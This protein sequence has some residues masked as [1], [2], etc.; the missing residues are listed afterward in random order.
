M[1]T[2]N[3]LSVLATKGNLAVKSAGETVHTK[4]GVNA[5]EGELV[6]FNPKTN[7]TLGVSDLATASSIAIGVGVKERGKVV[8]RHVGGDSFNLKKD[9]VTVTATAPSC[10]C[11]Q[12]VDIFPTC[13]Q[14]DETY[15]INI[16][17]DDYLV[18]SRF[19]FNDQLNYVFTQEL[20]CD[21]CEDCTV[22]AD[23][24]KWLSGLRDKINGKYRTELSKQVLPRVSK[25]DPQYQP[26]KASLLYANTFTY[27]LPL[28]D[29]TCE[30]C[31]NFSA[32]GGAL[33]DNVETTFVGTTDP[34]D[35]SLTLVE[36][37]QALEDQL[38][39]ALD[40][41]GGSAYITTSD[42]ACC[43]WK[44]EVNTC[45]ASFE[46]RDHSNT[47]ISPDSTTNPLQAI[48][49]EGAYNSCSDNSST[50]TPTVGLRIFV[51]PIDWQIE[52]D[53]LVDTNKV[54]P[55]TWIRRI[56]VE[57][58]GYGWETATL[59]TNEVCA[60]QN[61]HGQGL[62]W[63]NVE[64]R[65]AHNGGPG[66]NHRM[67]NR[68]IG[69]NGIPDE[70]SRS[71]N[72]AVNSKETYCVYNVLAEQSG[73]LKGLSR[74]NIVN[75]N[76]TYL[77]VPQGDTTT[78]TSVELYLNKLNQLGYAMDFATCL[79]VVDD[80]ND[81]TTQ[82]EETFDVS[83]NDTVDLSE[84]TAVTYSIVSTS[85]VDAGA[86]ISASGSLVYTTTADGAYSIG[87]KVFC[88]G[89]LV[90]GGTVSGTSTT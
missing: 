66:R 8:L 19:D 83:T 80:V 21:G 48:T 71:R 39:E 45:D 36:Q 28:G 85:N 35:S 18:R 9:T 70:F 43:P 67:S 22:E 63:L 81:V 37:K 49:K 46:L 31:I 34:A 16:R 6:V 59:H 13:L 72:L 33:V 11:P 47:L 58:L 52:G 78:Q 32:I 74:Y 27:N 17:L 77:L 57:D 62:Y 53:G 76:L 41:V 82:V 50:F 5:K 15:S 73:R 20:S 26:F 64:A 56:N 55:N 75:N 38:N 4:Y 14:C 40:A 2:F 61:I 25:N 3:R 23:A 90:G 44:L 87:Y 10:G 84:C 29:G 54:I 86:T 68:N 60:P 51:D 42:L 65:R 89:I 69:L 88:D 1:N 12:V 7:T 24:T 30:N 79:G